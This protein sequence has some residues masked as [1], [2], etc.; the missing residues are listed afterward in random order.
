[1]APGTALAVT[2]LKNRS[3]LA[4]A[5]LNKRLVLVAL[6][7]GLS[8]ML[9]AERVDDLVA[10]MQKHY[11]SAAT[12]SVQFEETYSI[13]GHARPPETGTLTLKKQGKMRWD[14][15]HPSGKL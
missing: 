5:R 1:M 9:R 12:L 14:Y 6:A 2:L 13:L 15:T 10:Q 4:V 11:N 8:G 3:A 7:F